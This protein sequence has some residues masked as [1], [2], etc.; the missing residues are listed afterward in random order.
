MDTD[1]SFAQR[2]YD[3]GQALFL[4][5]WIVV[6]VVL[7]IEPFMETLIPQPEWL[8]KY[9]PKNA[10]RKH[11]RIAAALAFV[12]ASFM[13]FDDVSQK[14]RNLASDKAKLEGE[15]KEIRRQHFE[16]T[17]PQPKSVNKE[18]YVCSTTIRPIKNDN[19]HALLLEFGVRGF[20]TNG[21]VGVVV[22]DQDIVN[23]EGW[24]AAPLRTDIPPDNERTRTYTDT[25]DGKVGGKYQRSF[26]SPSIT[27]GRSEYMYVE[28]EKPFNV[29]GV[30][31]LEDFYSMSDQ[32]KAN[33]LAKSYESCPR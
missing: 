3:F 27:P 9:W 29:R 16:I 21:F 28:A 32:V 13:A 10:R 19:N 15:L 7:G 8:E 31:F 5:W 20:S 1:P 4:D 17:E 24:E 2:I 23:A 33:K 25:A 14:S 18:K 26:A 6:G 12:A 11:F 22:I 30:L